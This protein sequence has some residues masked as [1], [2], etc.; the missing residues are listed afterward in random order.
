MPVL[1]YHLLNRWRDGPHSGE[2][3]NVVP[4]LGIE[5]VSSSW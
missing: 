1:L 5:C 2:D 3:K 4:L